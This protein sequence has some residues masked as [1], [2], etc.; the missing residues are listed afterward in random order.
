MDVQP[1]RY[2]NPT[3]TLAT[4]HTSSWFC[5]CNADQVS[6]SSNDHYHCESQ[7]FVLL[8]PQ[9][10][11]DDSMFGVHYHHRTITSPTLLDGPLK[12]ISNLV[13]ISQNFNFCS[14]RFL[15]LAHSL[16]QTVNWNFKDNRSP[17]CY[18]LLLNKKKIEKD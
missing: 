17:H 14:I 11:N 2:K 16:S 3:S 18:L 10:W 15:F 4:G 12:T 1:W 9:D 6:I 5:V 8:L 13:V 7:E